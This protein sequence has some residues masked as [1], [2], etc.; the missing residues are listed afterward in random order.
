MNPQGK[1]EIFFKAYLASHWEF[2]TIRNILKFLLI[3]I[4][5]GGI[6]VGGIGFGISAAIQNFYGSFIVQLIGFTLFGMGI[7]CF[8]PLTLNWSGAILLV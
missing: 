7:T 8:I 4:I 1:T 5:L 2:G 6:T 3:Y